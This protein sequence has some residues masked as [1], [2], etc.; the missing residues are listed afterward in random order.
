MAMHKSP[1]KG[2]GRISIEWDVLE[3]EIFLRGKALV[4][5]A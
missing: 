3:R 1:I 2:P 4:Q 5:K